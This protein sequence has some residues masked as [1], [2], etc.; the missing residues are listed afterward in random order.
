MFLNFFK[1]KKLGLALGG[2]ATRGFAH[3]GVLKAFEENG[4][5][6]DFIAGTSVGSLVGAMY[7]AGF[8]ADEIIEISKTLTPKD[9]KTNKIFFMPSGP[10]GIMNLIKKYI[11]DIDVSELKTPFCAV[12][13]DVKSGNE[14]D[15]VK[16]NLAAAVAGSCAVPGV[17]SDVKFE[18]YSLFDGGL[19]NNLPSNIPKMYGCDY[20][21]A[22]DINSTRGSGT[23]SDKYLD[24][25]LAAFK[26]SMKSNALKGYLNADIMIQPDLKRFN[27]SQ[28][29]GI[30]E[31]IEEGY[32]AT[33]AKMPEIKKMLSSFFKSKKQNN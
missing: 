23:E 9:I 13:S 17:F 24:K 28:L 26:M 4:I 2:G 21:I 3:L 5:T 33:I 25:L 14:V 19:L 6:F 16:G 27:A 7:A 30:D 29:E 11:G 15:I 12:A 18:N 8:K 1:K 20:V 31:M 10:E 32:K 22:V